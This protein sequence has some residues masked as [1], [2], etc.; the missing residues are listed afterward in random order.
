MVWTPKLLRI[1]GTLFILQVRRPP[2]ICLRWIE[3][4]PS[5]INIKE[6]GHLNFREW[7]LGLP[8]VLHQI[9]LKFSWQWDS[10]KKRNG[11]RRK[12]TELK[13]A[14]AS[15]KNT[16][17][18]YVKF[19][20]VDRDWWGC[21]VVLTEEASGYRLV[22]LVTGWCPA[23]STC[24]IRQFCPDRESSRRNAALVELY[25]PHRHNYM[26]LWLHVIMKTICWDC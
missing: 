26:C 13:S 15:G 2:D 22:V 11:S 12:P 14:S 20:V 1:Q 17:R 19:G 3:V 16:Q 9:F 4:I 6:Y 25:S 18:R 8:Q 21:G 24:A 23:P 7:G 10:D 5:I